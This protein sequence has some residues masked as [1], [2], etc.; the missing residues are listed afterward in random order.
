MKD[1]N[2]AGRKT[3]MPAPQLNGYAQYV[4]TVLGRMTRSVGKALD[5]A[6]TDNPLDEFG[7]RRAG[8]IDIAI[9]LGKFSTDLILA[10]GKMGATDEK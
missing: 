10:I 7:H 6:D 5:L 1:E 2:A 9:K 3:E 4:E 8:E